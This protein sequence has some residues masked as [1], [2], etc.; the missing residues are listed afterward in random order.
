MIRPVSRRWLLSSALVIAGAGCFSIRQGA[1]SAART[2][3]PGPG[4][5]VSPNDP[6]I[7]AGAVDFA[8]ERD[9]ILAYRAR[10]RGRGPFPTILLLPD[11][12]GLSP[13]AK[14][15]A[16]RLA[17]GGY[18]TLAIDF[19]SR[20]G[21]TDNAGDLTALTALLNRITPDRA[22]G[23]VA[24]AVHYLEGLDFVDKGA[25]GLF[26]LDYGGT[27]AWVAAAGLSQIRAAVVV[28]GDPPAASRLA[29]IKAAVLGIYAEYDRRQI[30]AL[31]ALEEA[32]RRAGVSFTPVIV[33]GVERGFLNEA[34]V[35]YN[36]AGA[37][38]AWERAV[39]FFETKLRG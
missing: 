27:V 16:R 38:E 39:T 11:G 12:R 18:L 20:S 10:P 9:R 4:A 7:D 1:T 25:L 13:Y 8:A 37:R 35:E 26:G 6:A 23:D 24:A 30:A 3:V 36:E 28:G 29:Q 31:P 5:T 2:P 14:E 32:T 22:A 34:N 33:K 21:G 19:L 15:M 17:K